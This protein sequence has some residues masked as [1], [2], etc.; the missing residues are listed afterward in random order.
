MIQEFGETLHIATVEK[1]IVDSFDQPRLAAPIPV[2]A[3]AMRT[4]WNESVSH[5]R[6]SSMTLCAL[7]AL[8]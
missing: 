2:I 8:C 7:A 5:L 3:N 6:C 4:A 1:A